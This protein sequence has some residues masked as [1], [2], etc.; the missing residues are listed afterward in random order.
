MAYIVIEKFGGLEY[1]AI[2]TDE[3][4]NNKIFDTFDEA[5]E[6]AEECQDGVVVQL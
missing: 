3:E 2:V 5:L 1:A 4:G 6:E